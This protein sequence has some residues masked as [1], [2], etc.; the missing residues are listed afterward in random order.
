MTK[1]EDEAFAGVIANRRPLLVLV[2][3]ARTWTED[4][5]IRRELRCLPAGSIILHGNARGADRLAGRVAAEL[6]LDVRPRPADWKSYGK[7]A[8]IVRNR[9]MLAEG[10]DVVLAFHAD[11]EQAKGTRH[12][13][14]IARQAGVPVRVVAG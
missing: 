14:R 1:H 11:L 5:P 7:A 6:N 4:A 3:G 8:G 13:V 9:E 12:M 2:T 10:P